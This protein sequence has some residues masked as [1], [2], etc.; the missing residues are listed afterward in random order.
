[1][2]TNSLIMNKTQAAIEAVRGT[3][4]VATRVMPWKG[5]VNFNRALASIAEQTGVFDGRRTPVPGR[6]NVS[7]TVTDVF[8]YEDAPWEM[9]LA[10]KGGVNGVT[11]AGT[12]P[13]YTYDFVPTPSVDDLASATLEVGEPGNAYKLVQAMINSWTIRM[14][15]DSEDEPAWMFEAELIA[16]SLASTTY[17]PALTAIK[18]EAIIAP[19]TKVYIDN[20]G[21]TPGTTQSTGKIIS[22]SITGNNAARLKAYLEDEGSYPANKV[23]RG[24][25]VFDAQITME[26]DNDTEFANYRAAAPVERI[27]RLERQGTQIHGASVVNKTAQLDIA[28]YWSSVAPG[29]R[30]G[31]MTMTFGLAGY[32]DDVLGYAAKA[33]FINKLATLA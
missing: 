3:A 14:D 17:T 2:A 5:V 4:Q 6:P 18:R 29:D 13:A 16:R 15:G 33:K 21:A 22:A 19:G 28:G 12:P 20:G 23:G 24:E 9:R 11:D 25:R 7:L 30:N 32:L 1:M 26:F 27:I 8:T 31:D 10:M